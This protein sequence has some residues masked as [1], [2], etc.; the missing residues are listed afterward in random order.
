[1][2]SL[3]FNSQHELRSGWKF[4]IFVVIL[5]PVW[6]ASHLGL[7]LIFAATFGIEDPLNALLVNVL[8]SCISATV[9]T[10]FVAR[11]VERVP[12]QV[13]GIGFQ[14]GWNGNLKTGVAIGSSLIV[15]TMLGALAFGET[16][17]EWTFSQA[18]AN[19]MALTLGILIVAAAFEELVF[20]GYPL[21][22]L[23]K[24]IGPWKAI[25][26]MSCIFGMLHAQNPNS[27]R[28]GIF[29][30]IVAGVML[31]LAYWK[32]RSLWFSYGLHLAWNVGLGMVVGFPLSGLGVASLWT[33]RVT[34]PSS[35]LG[36]EYG[37]EGGVLG[38]IIF[39]VGA[40][41]VWRIPVQRINYDDRIYKDSGAG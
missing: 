37:P 23:I 32:T 12:L 4:A 3:F 20:R 22:I 6:I 39:I 24:G 36:G 1:M 28:L 7:T 8:A 17:V 19:Q 16:Q 35:I 5:L 41:A 21:Q 2:I 34:G 10:V 33:T 13:M 40:I 18:A 27:S 15:L 11:I 30:T 14:S 31:S 25:L 29:N 26:V 9:A 38:T